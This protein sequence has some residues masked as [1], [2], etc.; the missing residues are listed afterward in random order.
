MN[1]ILYKKSIF[2]YISQ[3]MVFKIFQNC[4]PVYQSKISHYFLYKKKHST[5][6]FNKYNESIIIWGG[7]KC[8]V[9]GIS[10]VQYVMVIQNLF[11][12]FI[13]CDHLTCDIIIL[14]DFHI[15]FIYILFHGPWLIIQLVVTRLCTPP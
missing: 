14:N 15:L 9:F 5:K 10:R 8:K 6:H 12:K 3:F 4:L 7:L 13:Q 2:H 11:M 1:K